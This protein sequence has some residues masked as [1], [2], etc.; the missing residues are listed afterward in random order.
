MQSRH[1]TPGTLFDLSASAQPSGRQKSSDCKMNRCIL[2]YD[3]NT[4]HYIILY[5]TPDTY[6][7]CNLGACVLTFRILYPVPRLP[8]LPV[9]TCCSQD[10]HGLQCRTYTV[11]HLD[12]AL[13]NP[14]HLCPAPKAAIAKAMSSIILRRASAIAVRRVRIAA[15]RVPCR[16]RM[17][18]M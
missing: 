16:I 10:E 17:C 7:M 2:I 1:L 4:Y 3:M 9:S 15:Q 8:V 5:L 18:R 14:P 6:C 11:Q 13:L 12:V